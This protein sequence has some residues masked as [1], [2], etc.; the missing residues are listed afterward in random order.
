[1]YLKEP[2]NKFLNHKEEIF[3]FINTTE[4]HYGTWYGRLIVTNYSDEKDVATTPYMR[5]TINDNYQ[6]YLDQKIK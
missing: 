6:K 3:S 2:I 5:I 4:Y 1:M